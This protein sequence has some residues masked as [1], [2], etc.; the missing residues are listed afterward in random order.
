MAGDGKRFF[1]DL[2]CVFPTL[3]S[4]VCIAPPGLR[5]VSCCKGEFG[6]G[7]QPM[8]QAIRRI[9]SSGKKRAG[10]LSVIRE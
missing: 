6:G 5:I 10:A 9:L 3:S 1:L 4:L 8:A 7:L 2:Y